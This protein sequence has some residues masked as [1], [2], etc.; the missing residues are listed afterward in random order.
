MGIIGRFAALL[1]LAG[2]GATRSVAADDATET[3]PDA[4]FP[5]RVVTVAGRDALAHWERLR[6][7]GQGW[8]VIIGN[9]EDL[10]RIRE[11]FEMGSAD[12]QEVADT[13]AF[14]SAIDVPGALA[15]HFED[16]YGSDDEYESAPVGEWPAVAPA[17]TGLTVASDILTGQPHA[18]VHI[19][20][21]PT[22]DFTEAPAHLRWGNWNACPAPEIHV[23]VLRRWRDSH[24]IELV[25]MSG[26]VINLRA[27]RRPSS[28][29]EALEL[30]RLQYF[31]CSDIVDQGCETISALAAAL[32][33]DDWWYF[34]WD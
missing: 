29:E 12:L 7:E 6:G 5:F 21:L 18:R 33:A 31:Y 3:A 34:W 17:P 25:G 27:T 22:Q 11:Q 1:G 2:T 23:A 15:R 26:D 10:D 16:E 30:A 24:G 19:V 32:M 13:L 9:D 28:R 20:I 14:A 4:A 8:P